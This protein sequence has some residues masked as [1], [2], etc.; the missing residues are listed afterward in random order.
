M[1]DGKVIWIGSAEN[2][3]LGDIWVA[4]GDNGLVAVIV[5]CHES[6]MRDFLAQDSAE[7]VRDEA[8]VAPY[9]EQIR[10]YVLGERHDFAMPID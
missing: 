10:Q 1:S 2:T 5:D 7:I 3:D 4:V 8:K 9:T 6:D